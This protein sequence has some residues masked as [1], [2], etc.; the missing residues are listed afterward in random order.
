MGHVPAS[1]INNNLGFCHKREKR[2]HSRFRIDA[3]L[4]FVV[5]VMSAGA[6]KNV[7]NGFPGVGRESWMMSELVFFHVTFHPV[8]VRFVVGVFLEA[9]WALEVLVDGSRE[10]GL[11]TATL[12][13]N[14]NLLNR[15]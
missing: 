8:S 11:V 15:V 7:S 13:T 2:V 3:K 4:F 10:N 5:G 14:D 6:K 9:M 1:A 12:Y